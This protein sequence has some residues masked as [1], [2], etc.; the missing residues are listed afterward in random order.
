MSAIEL[1]QKG[2][3]ALRAGLDDLN[4]YTEM[5]LLVIEKCGGT[6]DADELEEICLD[7]VDRYGEDDAIEAIRAGAVLFAAREA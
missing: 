3:R 1:T 5:M 6:I 4:S 2:R 7:L